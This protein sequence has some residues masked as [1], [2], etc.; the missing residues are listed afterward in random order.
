MK[1]LSRWLFALAVC[2]PATAGADVEG[3][4]AAYEREVLQIGSDLPVP[5]ALTGAQGHRRLVDAEVAYSLGDYEQAALMLFDLASKQSPDQETATF[6]LAESLYMKGDR[7]A[8]R[9]YYE[10]VAGSNNTSSRYY[11]PSLLRLVEIAIAQKDT[12]NVANVI[13]QLD[14]L[15]PGLRKPE[16]P[17]VRG[18]FAFFE[19]KYDEALAYFNDVAKG[20]EQE[21]QA[22][23]YSA[24]VYVAKKDLARATEMFNDLIARKPKSPNDRRVQELSHMALGRLHY[25]RDQPS[26]SIDS[27]LEIDRRSDLFP[28]ALYEVAWVYVKGKQYDKAL[29]ALELLSLSEPTSTKTPTVRILEG[30]L[31]I[32]KAQMIR[33]ARIA[34]TIDAS[35]KDIDPS[36]EYDK[37][38]GV[39]TDTHDMYLPSY[40][41]L[42]EM[43][44]SQDPGQYLAQLAGR[45]P[46]VFQTT[47]PVPEAAAQYLREE[48][49]VQRI[50]NVATDLGEVETNI[51]QAEAVLSRLEGVLAAG[52]KTAVY[53]ALQNR[54]S[55]IGA[56][57]DDLIKIRIELLDRAG[58][59]DAN[60]KQL[61]AAY[62]ALGN[63]EQVAADRLSTVRSEYDKLDASAADVSGILDS[64]QAVAV[65]L[66]KYA[67]DPKATGTEPV[68]A[69]QK[70]TITTAL[71]DTA[72]EAASIEAELAD[73]Q[74]E[75][76]L[77]RDLAAV[78]DDQ[79][80]KAREARKALKAALDAEQ[81]SSGKNTGLL[82]RAMAVADNLTQVEDRID[83]L[84]GRGMEQVKAQIV[85]ERQN[86]AAMRTELAEHN[87]E[88]RTIG[89]TALGASFKD[90]KAKFYDI[91]I[92]TDVGNVDVAWSRKEDNDDDLKRLN[93][94]R[95]RDLKQLRDEFRGIIDDNTKSPAKPDAAAPLKKPE[96]EQPQQSPD[97]G[98][99][100]GRVKPGEGSKE[101]PK[102]TVRPD[103][104]TKPG[105]Q[106]KPNT[107]PAT[108]APAG[109]Q[110]KAPAAGGPR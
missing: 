109:T 108:K 93:L 90:V 18:K 64:T 46:K 41:A 14:R 103:N 10:I 13:A 34:G 47:S 67:S 44:E 32:R 57:Q 96:G 77:G 71:D 59:G 21:M 52:D 84:V 60:R 8:A 9:N 7:G 99:S 12:T 28:D 40:L 5:N 79:V 23:Y 91:V 63:A 89:G 78:G 102:P 6:Y 65:A 107:Q 43:A 4:V 75:L 98:G 82:Q 11:Q 87:S 97:K 68:P 80:I 106:P 58:S 1:R 20:S 85:T 100:D 53:P 110:P 95:Q 15:S 88:A 51:I 33:Q 74:R 19:G 48:P 31:R 76:Q 49:E 72:K 54:R 30:N 27:Y 26:K 62:L 70:T 69:D 22:T 50:V 37:A 2:L 25:E 24:T 81:R 17:Y 3:R 35:T 83:Q 56:I 92:R 73:I 36:A 86:I 55:R 29:R 66:R 42:S 16:V 94:S 104:E 105:T 101:P 38:E 45:A 39:F 61:A